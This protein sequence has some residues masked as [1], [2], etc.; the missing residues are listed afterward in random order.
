MTRGVRIAGS[1]TAWLTSACII[2]V[3]GWDA[4]GLDLPLAHLAGS[5]DGFPWRDHW[6]LSTVLHNGVRRLS[7]LFALALCVAVWWPAGPLT[8]LTQ[9]ARLQLAATTL[10]AGLVV[11][12]LK[13]GSRTSCPWELVDFG[14]VAHYASHWTM[15]P[16]GGTGRCFPAGHAASGFSFL[17]GYFAFRPFDERM[18]RLWLATSVALGMV[19]GLA[20]QWRGAHFM[21][22]T[23]WTAAICWGIALAVDATWPLVWN[24][25]E[26]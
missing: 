7:W 25:A 21:S 9:R 4:A 1:E 3:L 11:S 18:A 13:I 14:G 2:L 15:R 24:T 12:V 20:Q 16:D 17:G 26:I 19:L 23:L 8:R 6:L 10:L 5:A 22:H